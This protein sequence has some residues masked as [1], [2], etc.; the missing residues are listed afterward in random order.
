ML[1]KKQRDH[2]KCPWLEARCKVHHGWRVVEMEE[3]GSPAK[4]CGARYQ[5][6]YLCLVS[7]SAVCTVCI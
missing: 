6:T 3:A 2:W 7:W 5:E 1:G 4:G